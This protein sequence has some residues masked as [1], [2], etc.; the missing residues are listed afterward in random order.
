[1]GKASARENTPTSTGFS[2]IRTAQAQLRILAFK[3][4]ITRCI[5]KSFNSFTSSC[6]ISFFFFTQMLHFIKM[7]LVLSAYHMYGEAPSNYSFPIYPNLEGSITHVYEQLKLEQ[8]ASYNE[9]PFTEVSQGLPS[10][11]ARTMEYILWDYF[12]LSSPHRK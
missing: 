4:P 1:M 8:S 9:S 5:F 12:I 6:C 2:R 7:P 3:A 11:L 10:D